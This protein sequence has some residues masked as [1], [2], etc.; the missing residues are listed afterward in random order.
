M[1]IIATVPT[2]NRP[3][4]LLQN[5]DCLL[6]QTR[7][8]DRIVIVD[9]ASTMDT[10]Q[11]MER[12]G[13]LSNPL[14]DYVRVDVN[15]GAS[16]GFAIAMETAMAQGADWIWGMDDDAFPRPDALERLLEVNASGEHDC[17]WS[18]LNEDETFAGPTKQVD[19]LVFVGFLVSRKLVEVVGYPDRRFYMYH[20]DT[21]YGIRIREH[22]FSIIK[23]RDSVIDHKGV[24]KRDAALSTYRLP[25]LGHFAVLNCEPFRIYYIFRNSYFI[26]RSSLERFLCLVYNMLIAFP[27]YLFI[28]P[29]SGIAISLATWHA[30]THK[31]GRVDLPEV[32]SKKYY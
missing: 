8:L 16:G 15:V 7:S 10:L 25:V 19:T 13:H 3:E 27:K 24:D 14:I 6:R 17:L 31:R 5:I 32:F 2:Y 12:A 9:N 21:E 1:K 20:D 11:V 23:V 4:L 22:G 26:K 18:N 30:L 28:R 29:W